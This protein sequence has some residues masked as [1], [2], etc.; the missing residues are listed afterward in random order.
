MTRNWLRCP[1]DSTF[2]SS[3]PALVS[4]VGVVEH[5]RCHSGGGAVLLRTI[6]SVLKVCCCRRAHPQ[7]FKQ[8]R[9]AHPGLAC[10]PA[11]LPPLRCIAPH[12]PCISC[13]RVS[14]PHISSAV[15]LTLPGVRTPGLFLPYV[16]SSV[17]A[18]FQVR[19][20]RPPALLLPPPLS[21]PSNGSRS[22]GFD[23]ALLCAC[24]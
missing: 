23:P 1:Y 12:V 19:Q 3:P 5:P 18:A 16:V 6:Q 17:V 8:R 10:L 13:Q 9:G 7:S 2:P 15:A 24:Q 22:C 21:L 14:V 11:C 4:M 20:P